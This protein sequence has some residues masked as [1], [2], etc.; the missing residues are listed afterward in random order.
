MIFISHKQETDHS[1]AIRVKNILKRNGISSWIAPEDVASGQDYSKE[2]PSAIRSCEVFLLILTEAAQTSEHIAKEINLAIKYN[3][4]IIPIQCGEIRLTDRYDYLLANI[5]IKNVGV[6]LQE[7]DEI[8]D[9]LKFGQYIY[10]VPL[11]EKYSK[12]KISV[13]KG[14][15]HENVK[16][17]IKNPEINLNEVTFVVGIDSS[18]RLDW[19]SNKGILRD[20][21]KQLEIDYRI[22]EER[23]QELINQAKIDQLNHSDGNQW[24]NYGDI[25]TIEVPVHNNNL[26]IL[27]I[28]NSRKK[29]GFYSEKDLDAVEGP[30]SRI[31]ILQIFNKCAQLGKAA[32]NIMIGAIG[33]NGLEFS[34]E[35]ITAEIFN[36][37]IFSAQK[38][39]LPKHLYYSVRLE[40]MKRAN[41]TTEKIY[42]YVRSVIK[43]FE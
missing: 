40:D 10:S 3:K 33:T 21:L 37:F 29:E 28:A 15:F 2:I 4:K 1:I 20:L 23:L 35:V 17:M 19:S 12:Y 30:D 36:A 34:Y 41:I 18:S 31:A 38:G 5:Q 24:M 43:F 42:N 25:I 39:N 8:L 6:N 32:T 11:G 26:Q 9:E 7:I 27:F 16:W 14:S 22:S 13:I